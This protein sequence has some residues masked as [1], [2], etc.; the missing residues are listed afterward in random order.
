MMSFNLGWGA[1]V[2]GVGGGCAVAFLTMVFVELT[3]IIAEMMLP[4]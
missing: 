1:V 2:V 3:R 4:P